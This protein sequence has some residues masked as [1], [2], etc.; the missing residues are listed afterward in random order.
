MRQSVTSILAAAK[1]DVLLLDA[2]AD[3]RSAET[4]Q[5]WRQEAI[6]DGENLPPVECVCKSGNLT[7]TLKD[8]KKRY[9]YIIVDT[10]GKRSREMSS[11]MV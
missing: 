1:K 2:D 8:L 6:A 11:A 3:Q 5:S 7:H 4:W 9:E 10:P